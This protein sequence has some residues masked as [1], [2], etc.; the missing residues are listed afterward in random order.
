M[1]TSAPLALTD[2]Q[3][4][5]LLDLLA[6]LIDQDAARVLVKPQA[7]APGY[8]FGGGNL[9][10]GA[11]DSLLLCGRYRNFGD[12]RTGLAAGERGLACAILRSDDHG[13]T[14][15]P[16]Q[17]WTKADLSKHGPRV[18]S[19]EG[20]AL[21]R[22]PGGGWE[23]FISMEKEVEYPA[24][25]QEFR[26]AGTGIWSIDRLSAPTLDGLATATLEPVLNA[27]GRPEYLHVKDPV[28]FDR[29]DGSTALIFCTH[30]FTW[31][32]SNSGLA[33]R[34]PGEH[35]FRV[36][37]WEIG[38]RGPAWDVA[39]TRITAQLAIPQVGLFADAPPASIYFY[40]G[41]E[42]LRELEQSSAGRRRPRGY[43][44]EEIGG[45]FMGWDDSFPALTRLSRLQ[46]LFISPWGT[47]VSRYVDVLD[48]DDG[49]LAIWQQG[50]ADGSQ[51]L[52][53]HFLPQAGVLR[54]LG[55]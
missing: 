26:K 35:A 42:S 53:G 34:G 5:G 10:H 22:L 27:H 28:V 50:Q 40:D 14:F 30:P 3:Q 4:R 48:R 37:D 32:S 1:T 55:G 19:I 7:D 24:P 49:L 33:L 21:H 44:C 11:D 31:A 45:A 20:T 51:P 2:A 8:W 43:S 6:A 54:L 9:V 52:V 17:Q 38:G 46:P 13:Q 29:P 15:Q 23:L 25:W 16:V 36:S 12:S 41:A 18:I 39:A 47:G